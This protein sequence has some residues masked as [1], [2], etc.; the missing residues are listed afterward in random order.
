MTSKYFFSA[1]LGG[2]LSTDL[3]SLS[4]LPKDAIPVT[5]DARLNLLAGEAAGQMIVPDQNGYPVLQASSSPAAP[6][7]PIAVSMMQARLAML[8]AGVLDKVQ[9]AIDAMVGAD[10]QAARIQ[11]QF[12]MEVRRDWPLVATL[13][14]S[15]G[16]TDKQVDELF[17]TAAAIV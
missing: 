15:L 2:F 6:A 11:W 4:S 12:A 14:K 10:G 5:D 17:L 9:T 13:Q 3:I 8:D 7:V 1:Q 16:L